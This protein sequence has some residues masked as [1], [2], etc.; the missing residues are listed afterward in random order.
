M[1]R[2][3]R[4]IAALLACALLLLAALAWPSGRRHWRAASLLTRLRGGESPDVEA[5]E[6]RLGPLR[7]HRYAGREGG[8]LVALVHGVHPDG[9]DEPRLVRFAQALAASGLVVYTPELPALAR[10]RL[11]PGGSTVLADACDAIARREQRGSLGV[12]GISFGGG[13]ALL[14][15]S[16]TEV[17]GAVLAIGAHH[18]A[19]ALARGWLDAAGSRERY[20]MQVLAHAYAGEYLE[21]VPDR[22]AAQAA[23]ASLLREE[24]PALDAL[25]PEARARIEPLRHGHELAPA[26]PRL[27]AI[28]DAHAAELAALSPAARVAELDVPVFLLHGEGDPLI[29]SRE[30][31]R[32]HDELPPRAR[33]GLLLTPLIGHADQRDVTLLEQLE[34]V[35]FM[36]GVLRALERL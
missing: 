11:D 7:A 17:I 31:R 15:A 24:A 33:G 13:L 16:Q 10:A 14:A 2:R 26:V 34:V 9:I 35:R 3:R 27:H 1:K 36:A 18:D 19:A 20:G 25:S 6:L 22:E 32:I 23:L 5:R 12:V 4:T 30:S 21:G 29:A 28:V 8:A